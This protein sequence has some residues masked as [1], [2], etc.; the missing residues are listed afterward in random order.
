MLGPAFQV[1]STKAAAR[2]QR[3]SAGDFA[4][5]W[6]FHVGVFMLE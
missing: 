6:M 5:V 2:E 4:E 1:E 3:H